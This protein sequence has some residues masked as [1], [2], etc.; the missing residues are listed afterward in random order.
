[1]TFFDPL[2]MRY[3][4][5]YKTP[6]GRF[7][8]EVE[9][10]L[11]FD[12]FAPRP[13]IEVLDVGC[14]TGNFSLKL[15][16][17]GCRVAGIDISPAMLAVARKKAAAADQDMEFL[18][19]DVYDLKFR[20]ET[21]DAVFS[22][23]CFEFITEPARA[24]AEMWRVLKPGGDLLIGA[25]HRDSA[26]GSFYRQKASTSDSVFRHAVFTTRSDLENLV[27]EH[28]IRI[29]ECVFV[30]PTAPPERFNWEEER[31][32]AQTERGGFIIATW[33]KPGVREQSQLFG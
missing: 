3:D 29:A 12:L 17:R 7:I 23:A 25:I 15:A 16:A 22:M 5:W 20:A 9:T 1:M 13:G 26:W 19:M 11:A 30:P 10:K 28:L 6:E 4:Q 14:G 32:L 18:E 31:R 33:H 8:D 21:F 24:F 2:A 27:P